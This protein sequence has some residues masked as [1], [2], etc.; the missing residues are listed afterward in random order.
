ML[1][2]KTCAITARLDPYTFKSSIAKDLF[3]TF[4]EADFQALYF[5]Y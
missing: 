2:L 1:E 4:A 3:N 5:V